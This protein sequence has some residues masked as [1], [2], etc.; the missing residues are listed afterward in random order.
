M[1]NSSYVMCA[2]CLS[3][4][5][6]RQDRAFKSMWAD[7]VYRGNALCLDHFDDIRLREQNQQARQAA[8]PATTN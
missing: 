8:Q 5:T 3:Q 4:Y 7:T 1:S 6:N 2:A